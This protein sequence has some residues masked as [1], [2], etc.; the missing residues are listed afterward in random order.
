MR[1]FML[2]VLCVSKEMN[3]D[4]HELFARTHKAESVEIPELRWYSKA[5]NSDREAVGLIDPDRSR[6]KRTKVYCYLGGGG[7]TEA[8]TNLAQGVVCR[9][10]SWETA[11]VV[12]GRVAHHGCRARA[13]RLP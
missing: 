11:V 2:V 6:P 8:S 5:C 4:R 13:N 3:L 9:T 10:Q 1:A 12:C 7:L